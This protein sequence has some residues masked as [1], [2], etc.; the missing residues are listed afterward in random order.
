MCSRTFAR[1]LHSTEDEMSD[2]DDEEDGGGED[3]EGE[4]DDSEE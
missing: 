3:S 2:W 4:E 1:A